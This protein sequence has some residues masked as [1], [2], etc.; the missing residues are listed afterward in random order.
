[1]A[2]SAKEV[3][4]YKLKLGL[5]EPKKATSLLSY[6]TMQISS[7]QYFKHSGGLSKEV[8]TQST[9]IMCALLL[10]VQENTEQAAELKKS[11]VVREEPNANEV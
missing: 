7:T 2:Y 9:L 5:A 10:Y 6:K 8:V 4:S 3:S 1:M 11:V